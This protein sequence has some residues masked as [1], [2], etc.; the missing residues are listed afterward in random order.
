MIF[1]LQT[2][3]FDLFVVISLLSK[4]LKVLIFVQYHSWRVVLSWPHVKIQNWTHPESFSVCS[5]ESWKEGKQQSVAVAPV[6]SSKMDQ[7]QHGAHGGGKKNK[8]KKRSKDRIFMD[9]SYAADDSEDD[10]NSNACQEAAPQRDKGVLPLPTHGRGNGGRQKYQPRPILSS[11]AGQFLV[12]VAEGS[13][14]VTQVPVCDSSSAQQNKLGVRQSRTDRADGNA[15]ANANS[16]RYGS[17]GKA[18]SERKGDYKLSREQRQQQDSSSS[19][20]NQWL[21]SDLLFWAWR[22]LVGCGRSLLVWVCFVWVFSSCNN[23]IDNNNNR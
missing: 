18:R 16:S 11:K 12:N 8:K 17:A 23:D 9:N 1:T 6:I 3:T 7:H 19:Q 15:N 2:Y 14:T 13:R 21:L 10:G 5:S 22:G 4:F 20:G